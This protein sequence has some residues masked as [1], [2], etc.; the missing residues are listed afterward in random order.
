MFTTLENAHNLQNAH[1]IGYTIF[2]IAY[3]TVYITLPTDT[4]TSLANAHNA[5]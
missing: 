4:L 5:G 2:E 3:N 1:N